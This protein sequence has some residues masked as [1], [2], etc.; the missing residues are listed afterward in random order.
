MALGFCALHQFDTN[1]SQIEE[2]VRG[3]AV[4]IVLPHNVAHVLHSL[5]LLSLWH[6][7]RAMNSSRDLRN[8]VRIHEQRITQFVRCT[9]KR[10]QDQYAAFIFPGSHKF[11]SEERRVGEEWRTCETPGCT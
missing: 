8:V 2:K 5:G 4:Y 3:P 11:R 6:F 7:Q 10:A 1:L 9:G